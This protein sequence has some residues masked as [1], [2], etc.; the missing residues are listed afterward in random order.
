MNNARGFFFLIVI[1]IIIVQPPTTN[2]KPANQ[3][4]ISAAS[5]IDIQIDFQNGT[6]LNYSEV[7]GTTVLNATQS[8]AEM[9]IQWTGNLAYVVAI[10][11]VSQ[12]TEM[13]STDQSLPIGTNYQR[14]IPLNGG[15]PLRHTQIQDPRHWTT[16]S[17]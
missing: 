16:H 11:G 2:A 14:G 1:T 6:V 15:E 13:E 9:E 12:D 17:L 7:S 4:I 8:I 3:N 5:G 10:D